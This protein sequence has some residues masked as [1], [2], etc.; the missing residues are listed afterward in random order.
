MHYLTLNHCREFKEKKYENTMD[1]REP[2]VLSFSKAVL[3][4]KC[5]KTSGTSLQYKIISLSTSCASYVCVFIAF[6]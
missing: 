1:N 6:G 3:W 5:L 4:L 2:P